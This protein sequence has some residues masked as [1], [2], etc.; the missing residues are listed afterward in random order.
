MFR[1]LKLWLSVEKNYCQKKSSSFQQ[2]RK[3]F[4]LVSFLTVDYLVENQVNIWRM[5][6]SHQETRQ[7]DCWNYKQMGQNGL[8]LR[9]VGG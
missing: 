7:T 5:K 9:G 2:T 6:E 8:K 1:R 4:H 3:K